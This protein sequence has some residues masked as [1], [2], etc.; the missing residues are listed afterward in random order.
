MSFSP[1]EILWDGQQQAPRRL[2]NMCNDYNH[3]GG[4]SRSNCHELH[5]CTLFLQ[6][7]CTA[8]RCN[9]AHALGTPRNTLLLESEGWRGPGDL[10]LALD[11]L[12][13]MAREQAVSI[14]FNYNMASCSVPNCDR[15]HVCYRRVVDTCP[16]DDCDLSHDLHDKH[17]TALLASAGLTDTPVPEL[18]RRLQEQV[19]HPPPQPGLC[20]TY[21][22]Q[23][24]QGHCLQLHY[25]EA[26]LHSR[27][28]FGDRCSRSHSLKEPHNQRVLTFFGWTEEQ[29]L[30][31][32]R[33]DRSGRSASR[34]PRARTP[35]GQEDQERSDRQG[36]CEGPQQDPSAETR[37][38]RVDTAGKD[39][40]HVNDLL[41]KSGKQLQRHY[42]V[43]EQTARV[44]PQAKE[45]NLSSQQKEAERQQLEAERQQWGRKE[46]EWK[47]KEREWKEREMEWKN[48]EAS[49]KNM[50]ADWRQKEHECLEKEIKTIRQRQQWQQKE[51]E[52]E[53]KET[54][55]KNKETEW[56][57]KEAEW[58]Q[59][60]NDWLEKERREKE[61]RET[62]ERA[63][64][65]PEDKLRDES[66]RERQKYGQEKGGD[67]R[68][69]IEKES[70]ETEL[71]QSYAKLII[72]HECSKK[73]MYTLQQMNADY[74]RQIASMQTL[75]KEL[76]DKDEEREIKIKTEEEDKKKN[77]E[78]LTKLRE[79]FQRQKGYV[80]CSVCLGTFVEPVTM[81]CAHTFCKTCIENTPRP[82]GETLHDIL[83]PLNPNKNR[84]CPLCRTVTNVRV[85][86]LALKNISSTFSGDQQRGARRSDQQ[87]G[88][89]SGTSGTRT[90][91]RRRHD[92]QP[93]QGVTSS[94][95]VHMRRNGE[96]TDETCPQQ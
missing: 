91:R 5:L 77:I 57:N 43:C 24:C 80:E 74:E 62:E 16:L 52:W 47:E 67:L 94:S 69:T 61:T 58:R 45:D 72:D 54:E 60:E 15:L 37:I 64:K 31:E 2:P 21:G 32:L 44:R 23:G 3:R 55:W 71:M 18:L 13:R 66:E 75:V 68:A 81:V 34:P 38:K 42:K 19:R 40:S 79:L 92:H 56:Q 65:E 48:K 14:C 26:F 28:R 70:R 36:L 90:R 93:A 10:A 22:K 6:N 49:W 86:T 82:A 25:C 11:I 83:N 8:E 4:C 78:E 85:P 46:T 50:K 76:K 9:K 30:E 17:N 59:K 20:G 27:C 89:A 95:E 12:R 96:G 87:R 35:T 53:E 7:R 1:P 51:T 73:T 33:K 29:V 39:V 88:A 41:E 84:Q 63:R